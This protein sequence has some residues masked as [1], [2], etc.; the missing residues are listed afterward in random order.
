MRMSEM[1]EQGNTRLRV[2]QLM[3]KDRERE[4]R[5]IVENLM[6][7]IQG[8]SSLDMEKMISFILR[9]FSRAI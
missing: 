8:D 3:D 1:V 6:K 4:R 9:F 7:C 2:M 5:G